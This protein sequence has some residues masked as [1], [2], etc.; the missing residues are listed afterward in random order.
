M[1]NK[2]VQLN[3]YIPEA[4]RDTLQRIAAE[5]MLREPKRSATASKIGAEII[6]EFLERVK[7]GN[8]KDED[9][10]LKND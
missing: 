3:L 2:K 7:K 4:Y 5:R 8:V 9:G 1:E 6:C 10:G